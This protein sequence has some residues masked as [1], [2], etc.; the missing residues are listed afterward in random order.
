MPRN[1]Q[2]DPES[3]LTWTIKDEVIGKGRVYYAKLVRGRAT[4]IARRLVPYYNAL[5]GMPRSR[6][7]TDLTLDACAVLKVLRREWEMAS[8][9][10]RQASG[11][12]D[13]V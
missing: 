2:K 13:R 5:W 9:D 7:A 12:V 11:I 6:E 8:R 4:F 10:L 3:R 1:V